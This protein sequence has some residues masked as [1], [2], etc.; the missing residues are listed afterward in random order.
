MEKE[1]RRVDKNGRVLATTQEVLDLQNALMAAVIAIDN[2]NHDMSLTQWQAAAKLAVDL[3]WRTLGSHAIRCGWEVVEAGY[4]N[5]PGNKPGILNRL[6]QGL[7][8]R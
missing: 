1:E 6:I 3:T 2:Y 7:E 5:S 4:E 8:E